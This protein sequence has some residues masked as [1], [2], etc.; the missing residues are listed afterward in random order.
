[1]KRT[2]VSAEQQAQARFG[3]ARRAAAF[4][5]NQRL[6]HVNAAMQ[7][8][9]ARQTMVSIATADGQ[10]RCDC[11]FRAGEPGFVHVLDPRTLAYPEYRGNGVMA[12]V[13]N[14][15]ENPHIGMIFLDYC[16]TTVGLHVNGRARVVEARDMLTQ[17][18]LPLPLLEAARRKG[19]RR[20]EAWIVIEV[21]EAYIHCSKHVP[22]MKQLDKHIEWGTDDDMAKGGD[23]FH[24]KSGSTVPRLDLEGG[25][26]ASSGRA[27]GVPFGIL[28]KRLA[29][30][31]SAKVVM[32]PL[33]V[34]LRRR[35]ARLHLH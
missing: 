19:G 28:L 14:V 15:L 10:G 2:V 27:A 16:H 30:T 13:G 18:H 29:A 7:D 9:I 21:E 26:P 23:F 6:D 1:M 32:L 33:V 5:A 35:F 22:L 3:T 24:I 20:P 4:D 8:F 11:S 34:A 17:P 31:L 12:S 25:A